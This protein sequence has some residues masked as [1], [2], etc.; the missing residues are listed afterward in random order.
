M[1][2]IINW[3]MDGDPAI[4]WQV[5]RDLL[6]APEPEWQAERRR[7]LETGWGAQFL[8][9]QDPDGR[10]G[11]KAYSEKWVPTTYIYGPKW[12]STTYTLLTLCSLGIPPDCAAARRGAELMVGALLGET[13]DARFR[14]NTAAL[15]RCI[16][17]M[18][19]QVGAYFRLDAAR[20][21]AI[22]DNLLEERF[23]DG[24][25]N[26][27]TKRRPRPTHSSFHTTFNVLD[28]LREY[29]EWDGAARRAEA[30]AAV[31]GALEFAL[32]H[33]LYKSHRT[34]EIIQ[35]DFTLMSFPFRWHYHFLRGLDYF[36]R[37]GAPRDPRF[38]DAIDL[39]N[40]KRRS[41]GTW[42][43]QHEYSGKIFFRMEKTGGPSRWNTFLAL[44]ILRWWE[45][46]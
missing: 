38:Q 14:Q 42:P 13:C 16:V 31:Q 4:R 12:V 21:E 41:D 40:E 15:D 39:L 9:L 5:M 34:G 46:N 1:D 26:C 7:T 45:N 35:P 6:D 24:G 23:P 17:G 19:L 29:L 18:A 22:L 2:P 27:A 37:A 10:W 36:A 25:W 8:A 28:G 33:R 3:L 20:I 30:L 32:R 11:G 44:R 43:V